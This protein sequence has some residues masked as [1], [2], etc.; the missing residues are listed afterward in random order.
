MLKSPAWRTLSLSARRVIDRVAIELSVH[1]G[2]DNGKLPVTFEQFAEY[3]IDRHA[4][5]PAIREA[6]A[7][8]FLEITEAG[9]AGNREW[10]RPNL[11]RITFPNAIKV[12]PTH[13]WR[14]IKTMEIAAMIA[15]AA[16]KSS[17]GKHISSGGKN[18]VSVGETPTENAKSL[19]GETPTT[20][21]VGETPTTFYISGMGG[22]AQ[23]A[24]AARP[25]RPSIPSSP[26]RRSLRPGLSLVPGRQPP[27]ALA[28]KRVLEVSS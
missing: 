2:H 4:I 17:P 14:A 10:R 13:E 26:T 23:P 19:V 15:R 24:H 8:G 20:A 27:T 3:G 25:T 9:R 22:S 1:G 21:A 5:G 7:L 18:H 28:R 16:R 12:D 6:V 11:F